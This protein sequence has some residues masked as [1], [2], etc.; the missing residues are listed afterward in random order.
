MIIKVDMELIEQLAIFAN[1]LWPDNLAEELKEDFRDSVIDGDEQAF[2]YK[3]EEV[4]YVGFIQLSLRHDYVEGCSS[5]PVAYIEG[6]YVE[7]EYRRRGIAQELMDYAV[8][9]G[10]EHGCTELASDCELDNELSI[11]F[12]SGS[13][14]EETNRLVCFKKD[15]I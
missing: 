6:I 5:S 7:D 1:K 8:V 10:K 11:L 14:F 3:I 12:H 15:I 2:L 13:G 9:W 4:G